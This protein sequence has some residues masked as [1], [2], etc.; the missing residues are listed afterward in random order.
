MIRWLNHLRE[1][2]RA[3][4][5]ISYIVST[6][7]V[8]LGVMLSTIISLAMSRRADPPHPKEFLDLCDRDEGV[9][10]NK[11]VHNVDGLFLNL[12]Q[13]CDA[14]CQSS[15]VKDGYQF[16]EAEARYGSYDI[17]ARD[18]GKYRF[19]LEKVGHPKCE[20]FELWHDDWRRREHGRSASKEKRHFYFANS[21][22]ATWP[23]EDF[24]ARYGYFFET[25]TTDHS[26]GYIRN[27]IT[28]IKDRINREILAKSIRYT[29]VYNWKYMRENNISRNLFYC[30]E[31]DK[32]LNYSQVVIPHK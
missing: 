19:T 18:P 30:P 21:C 17:F 25:K 12:G 26:F 11:I 24:S 27:S 23:I 1:E 15:L 32:F 16:V 3:W 7:A 8:V 14:T 29:I 13:G 20:V 31:G 4:W 6:V 5:K 22:V 9:T 28:T 2:N 10:I